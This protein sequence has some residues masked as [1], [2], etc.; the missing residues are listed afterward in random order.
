MTKTQRAALLFKGLGWIGEK[1]KR[2]QQ[3]QKNHQNW[4]HL[5]VVSLQ[6]LVKLFLTLTAGLVPLEFKKL[7]YRLSSL[8][9]CLGN[10]E[11]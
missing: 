1:K 4:S 10:Y 7:I 9:S 8:A 2:K 3:Q 5:L 6:Q 11:P